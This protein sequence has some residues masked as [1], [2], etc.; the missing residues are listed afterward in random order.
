VVVKAFIDRVLRKFS[1]TASENQITIE[2]KSNI[3]TDEAIF[4]PDRIEQ[5]LTNLIQNALNHTQEKGVVTIGL[6]SDEDGLNIE[7]TDNGSGIPE[8]DL[9]FIFERFYKA[10]KARTRSTKKKGTGLGLAIAKNI[11][12]A[13]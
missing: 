2:L 7:I 3:L 1:Q 6:V 4:D 13:H 9:P 8:E 10:D 12:D 5:V 11:I